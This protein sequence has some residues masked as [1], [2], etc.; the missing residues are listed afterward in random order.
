MLL[1]CEIG[2]D[3]VSQVEKSNSLFFGVRNK[4]I[5]NDEH[6]VMGTLIE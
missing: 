2:R 1:Y 4:T 3:I 6:N 5:Q